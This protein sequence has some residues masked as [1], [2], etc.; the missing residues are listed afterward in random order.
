MIHKKLVSG[1]LDDNVRMSFTG[2]LSTKRLN[3]IKSC[4][5][6]HKALHINQPFFTQRSTRIQNKATSDWLVQNYSGA[7][8]DLWLMI[9]LLIAW[10]NS[11]WTDALGREMLY[12]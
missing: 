5:F 6:V 10:W 3:L 2:Y 8:D 12:H 7:E 1:T 9:D 11:R 4:L